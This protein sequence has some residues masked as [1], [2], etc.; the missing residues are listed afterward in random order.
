MDFSHGKYLGVDYGDVRTGLAE[1]DASGLVA[2]GIA[3]VKEGGM[4]NTAVRVAKEAAARSCKKIIVGL[5]K[6]MDGSEGFRAQTVMA[7]I[8]LL[9]TETDI[10]VETYDER[11][12]TVTAYRFLDETGTHGK[13][14][15]ETIDTL[16]AQIILQDYLDREKRTAR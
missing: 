16:S 5:P 3:T 8:E 11:L 12:S 1:C 13:K 15:R 10:P 14:R 6:N 4:R 2:S 9:K 7:F